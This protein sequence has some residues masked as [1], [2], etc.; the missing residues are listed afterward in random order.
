[1]AHGA[2]VMYRAAAAL[3]FDDREL[4]MVGL[5]S[6]LGVMAAAA[7]AVPDWSTLS[8]EGPVAPVNPHAAD[9]SE[10]VATVVVTGSSG[11]LG[12]QY[13]AARRTQEPVAPPGGQGFERVFG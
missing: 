9:W 3:P 4:A 8:V 5:R 6:Q 7:G 2:F 10:W 11:G 12:G 13:R 1:M